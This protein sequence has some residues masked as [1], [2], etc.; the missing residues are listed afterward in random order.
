ME[1]MK[2]KGESLT[3]TGKS[4]CAEAWKKTSL[5][6][7][8]KKEG[9]IK[10]NKSQE[11]EVGTEKELPSP[12][13]G[14]GAIARPCKECS[15]S[16][17]GGHVQALFWETEAGSAPAAQQARASVGRSSPGHVL[18]LL[19]AAAA[20]GD[21]AVMARGGRDARLRRGRSRAAEHRPRVANLVPRQKAASSPARHPH[22]AA[23]TPHMRR[24]RVARPNLGTKTSVSPPPPTAPPP[25]MGI[26][27][28]VPGR[29]PPPR[30]PPRWPRL[31]LPQ[32]SGRENNP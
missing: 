6:G 12:C 14:P 27:A 2:E 28:A 20:N 25:H 1:K 21:A 16:S 15:P 3:D 13:L 19:A 4:P 10:T 9:G 8:K 17:G 32:L 24:D 26:R 23:P 11:E 5:A 22:P 18:P 7:K 31:P 30:P 29:S